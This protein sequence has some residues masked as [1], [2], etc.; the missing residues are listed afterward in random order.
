MTSEDFLAW[1]AARKQAIG[2]EITKIP[3]ANMDH[4]GFEGG[5]QNL[6]HD[7]GKFFA[8]EGLAVETN[9]GSVPRWTQ[10]IINQNEI[11]FLGIIAKKFDGVLCFLMQCKIEPGNINFVQLSPTLQ[12][13]KSNYSQV[14]KGNA[15]LY[16]EYFLK[17]NRQRHK[18]LLDQLQSE[19]GARFLKKRNRN[20]IIEVEE[21]VHLEDDFCWL[22]LGQIHELLKLDNI[23]NMDTRTVISGIHFGAYDKS[24]VSFY[25]VLRSSFDFGGDFGSDMLS[26][27]IEK[28]NHLHSNAEI[29]SWFTELKSQYEL[30]VKRIGLKDLDEWSISE[31]EITHRDDKYFKVI[32]VNAQISNRE[33]ASW[34][35]PLVES[36]QHG[37]IAFVVK[38][39]N[40]VY[41]FLVQAKLEAG[42]LDVM[43]MAPTVQCL[44]G[45]YR[46]VENVAAPHFLDYVLESL[47]RPERILYR[48][49]QSEEGG[50]FYKEQNESIIIE[51]PEDFDEG[52]PENYIWMT[53]NQ[54]KM[55]IT[56]NNYLNIQSRSL[57]SAI[58]FN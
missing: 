54:L 15:P 36:V 42:N 55:F 4:W 12:A 40:G 58:R 26:S 6:R 56:F 27:A 18:V 24:T 35:Q 48:T 29:I 32:A 57:I 37:I 7:S 13:T 41:H 22:T 14:H 10:P 16:L 39:I 51:A 21:E 5:T 49:Y 47:E 25:D 38:R 30:S 11:G 53:L 34:T 9:W 45:N 31:T 23:I 2:V 33:V 52:L 50:R 8:I 3:F 28:E 46:D 17:E 43:E 1:L 20:I 44:T 19:Q